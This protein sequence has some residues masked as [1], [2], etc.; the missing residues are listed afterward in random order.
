MKEI[1]L[2][3]Q[4]KIRINYYRNEQAISSGIV[5]RVLGNLQWDIY[6][7]IIVNREYQIN[8]L[9]VDYALMPDKKTPQVFI[10]VKNMGNLQ[11]ADEQLFNY[12]FHKGVPMAITT[13][14]R[15]WNF[16]LPTESGDYNERRVCQLNFLQDNVDEIIYWLKRYLTFNEALSS[17]NIKNARQ[18]YHKLQQEKKAQDSIS[19]AW[20]ELLQKK[21]EI[22]LEIIM[23]KV[24][25]LCDNSPKEEHVWQYI[26]SLSETG[27]IKIPEKLSISKQQQ[28]ANSNSDSTSQ[29]NSEE[30][31]VKIKV[32]F[33]DGTIIKGNIV[34]DTFRKTIE[35]I[36]VE[37]VEQKLEENNFNKMGGGAIIST[38]KNNIKGNTSHFINA[39]R[40]TYYISA[41]S[42]TAVKLDILKKIKHYFGQISKV[43]LF[44]SNKE[45]SIQT[46]SQEQQHHQI[47][48][49]KNHKERFKVIFPNDN[50]EIRGSN[51]T[52]TF[53][54]VIQKIGL[55]TVKSI[56]ERY[57]IRMSGDPLISTNRNDIKPKRG[58]REITDG[59][60]TY[61]IC[62]HSNT[63]TQ[64]ATL[65]RLQH[66][67]GINFKVEDEK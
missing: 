34:A 37:R 67:S 32:I 41:L 65:E 54:R 60:V 45:T 62:T 19:I 44:S 39:N 51:D 46:T 59:G 57:N 61:F 17:Q 28:F 58:F 35:K 48:S 50:V 15:I 12:A 30:P 38:N 20:S 9:R 11:G 29:K 36:G 18:D 66:I 6:D 64:K 53:V 42:S 1:I 2:D 23:E 43:E 55:A 25:N 16:Y 7:T 22:L 4:E 24:Q 52:D 5:L 27:S 33:I 26:S 21:D 31:R 49:N 56:T 14:G 40:R 63:P 13:D 3:I 10:E 47:S 8:S